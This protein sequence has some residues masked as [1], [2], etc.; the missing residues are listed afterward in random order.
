MPVTA[1]RPA[2]SRAVT[3]PTP[4]TAPPSDGGEPFASRRTEQSRTSGTCRADRTHWHSG[5]FRMR[6]AR[7]ERASGRVGAA[8]MWRSER[9]LW[10]ESRTPMLIL[11]R[12]IRGRSIPILSRQDQLAIRIARRSGRRESTALVAHGVA[13]LSRGSHHFAPMILITRCSS[14]CVTYF[15]S[16]GAVVSATGGRAS[17][18]PRATG[19]A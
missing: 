6:N 5:I 13:L 1:P 2:I 17:T 4:K 16:T 18:G 14:A 7:N 19:A 3:S 10:A 15:G 8:P 12:P 11:R 9:K